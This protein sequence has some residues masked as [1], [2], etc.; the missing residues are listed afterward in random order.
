MEETWAFSTR[1]SSYRS[2]PT[3]ARVDLADVF[4]EKQGKCNVLKKDDDV[5]PSTA[6]SCTVLLVSGRA[7]WCGYKKKE[8]VLLNKTNQPQSLQ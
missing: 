3:H 8:T 2:F 5:A 7:V 6:V 4:T 1:V